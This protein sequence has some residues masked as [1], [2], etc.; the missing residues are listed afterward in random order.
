MESIMGDSFP[1]RSFT[2]HSSRTMDDVSERQWGSRVP[3]FPE[4]QL[5]LAGGTSWYPSGGRA[6][7]MKDE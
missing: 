1:V 5:E 7:M 4:R 6:H 3:T 2:L